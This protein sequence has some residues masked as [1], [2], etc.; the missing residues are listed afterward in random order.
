M[1][2]FFFNLG[3]S[4]LSGIF[5]PHQV[6]I[7]FE[8]KKKRN[9]KMKDIQSTFDCFHLDFMMALSK[10][11]EPTVGE[12]NCF[13]SGKSQRTRKPLGTIICKHVADF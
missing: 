13:S 4:E 9:Y 3:F 7:D 1:E 2:F 8:M 11:K 5:V 6:C 12:T 10:L